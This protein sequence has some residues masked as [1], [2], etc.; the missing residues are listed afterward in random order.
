MK[1]PQIINAHRDEL[2]NLKLNKYFLYLRVREEMTGMWIVLAHFQ[3][4]TPLKIFSCLIKQVADDF[5][6][7]AYAYMGFVPA[8][9]ETSSS[10]IPKLWE[11]EYEKELAEIKKMH[12]PVNHPKHYTSGKIEVADFIADQKLNFFEGNVVKYVARHKHKNGLEDLKKARWYLDY[13]IKEGE[14]QCQTQGNCSSS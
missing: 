10:F 5:C 2:N 4:Q 6:T 14:K 11:S 3:N 8:D 12:D 1:N 9:E 7:D 13:L